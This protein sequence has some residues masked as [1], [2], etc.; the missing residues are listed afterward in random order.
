MITLEEINS[1]DHELAL[2]VIEKLRANFSGTQFPSTTTEALVEVVNAMD[3]V[4]KALVFLST[5]KHDVP[6]DPEVRAQLI[7]A[8]RHVY[9]MLPSMMVQFGCA[10]PTLEVVHVQLHAYEDPDNKD[11]ADKETLQ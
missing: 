1:V 5:Y 3:S 4:T 7:C 11:L 6:L 8:A 9:H 2:G 10:P